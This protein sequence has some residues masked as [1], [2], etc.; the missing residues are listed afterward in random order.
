[1]T[2]SLR[3]AA[4]FQPLT[5]TGFPQRSRTV[6][7]PS[8]VYIP[9]FEFLGSGTSSGSGAR[10]L[11]SF[12]LGNTDAEGTYYFFGCTIMRSGS[13][14]SNQPVLTHAGGS[15]VQAD[16]EDNP[17][18]FPIMQGTGF[19]FGLF[20]A[21]VRPD[22]SPATAAFVLTPADSG[23]HQ[24]A[25]AVFK[26]TKCQVG[27]SD[28]ALA[29]QFG[30]PDGAGSSGS[31]AVYD[32]AYLGSDPLPVANEGVLSFFGTARTTLAAGFTAAV[33]LEDDVAANQIT[34]V[35]TPGSLPTYLDAGFAPAAPEVH[36]FDSP[37]FYS[38]GTVDPSVN[39][40]TPFTYAH[41]YL[42][43]GIP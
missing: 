37:V 33:V 2:R 20:T 32:L 29:T 30:Q 5:K 35:T 27:N 39:A 12:A 3:S 42:V 41:S 7:P 36:P 28:G 17:F 26:G 18:I 31:G 14:I 8:T 19:A 38:G 9:G 16:D 10:S 6:T 24:V 34:Q 15:V 23:S 25:Y 1:M 13:T 4:Q 43:P 22:Q 21:V 11:G 40:G